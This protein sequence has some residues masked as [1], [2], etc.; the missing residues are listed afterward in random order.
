VAPPVETPKSDAEVRTVVDAALAKLTSTQD[1]D[2]DKVFAELH[3][4]LKGKEVAELCVVLAEPKREDAL[5][6]RALK[7][8]Q[9]GIATGDGKAFVAQALPVLGKCLAHENKEV[10][11]AALNAIT[12]AQTVVATKWQVLYDALPTACPEILG[13]MSYYLA[14]CSAV[15][16]NAETGKR[17][18]EVLPSAPEGEAPSVVSAIQ[19]LDYRDGIPGL[20][21][22]LAMA[23]PKGA[24]AVAQLMEEWRVAEAVPAIQE[25]CENYR[26]DY[27]D[28]RELS[29]VCKS[30][31]RLCGTRSETYLARVLLDAPP[32]TQKEFLDYWPK[33]TGVPALMVAAR[34]ISVTARDPYTREALARFLKDSRPS[35]TPNTSTV[36]ETSLSGLSAKPATPGPSNPEIRTAV[37]RAIQA[38]KGNVF[39]GYTSLTFFSAKGER[40]AWNSMHAVQGGKEAGELCL[41]VAESGHDEATTCSALT[42]LRYSLRSSG[43]RS[44][45]AAALTAIAGLFGGSST[46]VTDEALHLVREAPLPIHEKWE[47]LFRMAD[48]HP[49]LMKNFTFVNSISYLAGPQDAEATGKLLWGVFQS[50]GGTELYPSSYTYYLRAVDYRTCAL[51]MRR[52]LETAKIETAHNIASLLSEWKVEGLGPDLRKAIENHRYTSGA[53]SYYFL[54][55]CTD[56]HQTEGAACAGYMAEVLLGT[57]ASAQSSLLTNGEIKKIREPVFLEAV[58]KLAAESADA[59]VKKAAASF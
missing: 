44:Y 30:L 27:T 38:M 50:S 51:G 22:Y 46:Q 52:L 28:G 25:A 35:E 3:R 15:S 26:Y 40:R 8:I 7:P 31:Y 12:G 59:E 54:L 37:T 58:K 17:L 33:D 32:L 19:K 53:S 34:E 41:F 23:P 29:G 14:D 2:V 24:V 6:L 1:A 9:R 49:I 57:T 43:G 16:R 21:A 55:L 39:G 36:T 4:T 11:S 47:F 45:A 42:L 18:V 56:L 10:A 20:L 48:N 13:S 5:R